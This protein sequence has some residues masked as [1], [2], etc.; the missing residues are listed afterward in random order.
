MDPQRREARVEYEEQR[1]V[2][3]I[4][5]VVVLIND[6]IFAFCGVQN[7]LAFSSSFNVMGT[8]CLPSHTFHTSLHM[9]DRCVPGSST[10]F[11]S[12]TSFV[13]S[14]FVYFC[15]CL[16]VFVLI[17]VSTF[18]RESV[19]SLCRDGAG[20]HIMHYRITSPQVC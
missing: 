6:H 11:S 14:F 12:T 18:I 10:L 3:Q 15:Y 9:H 1:L 20:A 5:R 4:K 8:L 2:K 13:Y 7:A 16:S 17:T 19:D